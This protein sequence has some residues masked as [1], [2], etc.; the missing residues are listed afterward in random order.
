MIEHWLPEE[1]LKTIVLFRLP[2]SV[3]D[4][5]PHGTGVLLNVKNVFVLVTCKHLILDKKTGKKILNLEAVVNRVDGTQSI[6]NIKTI[7][8]QF[9]LKWFFHKNPDV[10]LAVSPIA[11][12]EG[13]DDIKTFRFQ[14][15]A[16]AQNIHPGDDVFF[17]GFPLGLGVENVDKISPLV[18]SGI[19]SQ[20]NRDNTYLIDA[21]VYP[22]SSGSPVFFRP[23]LAKMDPPNVNIGTMRGIKMIGIVSQSI[24]LG[25][26][27]SGLGIVQSCNLLTEIVKSDEFQ[28]ILPGT[29]KAQKNK[30]E[31]AESE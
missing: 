14:D 31:K 8:R 17:L 19:V 26:D 12:E 29:K 1:F 30:E 16:K 24:N 4:M 5:V 18:R 28:K 25:I 22:G 6:K 21:N 15:V 13:K 20:K 23:T 2:N 7:Q 27:N 9:D 10:D 11:I 3:G